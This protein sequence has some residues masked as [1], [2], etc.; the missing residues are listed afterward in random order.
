VRCFLGWLCFFAEGEVAVWGER[1]MSMP[2]TAERF[3]TAV[4]V[5]AASLTLVIPSLHAGAGPS[6]ILEHAARGIENHRKGDAMVRFVRKDG[7]P[8]AGLKVEAIQRTHDFAF[9]NLFRP[10]HYTNEIYPTCAMRSSARTRPI[11]TRSF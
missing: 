2:F 5:I 6:P 1:L 3:S 7:T 9:G 4:K 8:A 11:P 10:R